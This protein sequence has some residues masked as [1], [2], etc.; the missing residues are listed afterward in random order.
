MPDPDSDLLHTW[1]APASAGNPEREAAIRAG[2]ATLAEATAGE[3]L[4]MVLLA[5][6]V[7]QL[8]PAQRLAAAIAEHDPKFDGDPANQ[9]TQ[10]AAAW[11][12][13]Q[14]LAASGDVA[15]TAALAVASA[16]F[17]GLATQVPELPSLAA[18]TL[19]ERQQLSRRRHPLPKARTQKSVITPDV[20]ALGA[21]TG[22]QLQAT[23]DLLT[24][25]INNIQRSHG[26][27]VDAVNTRVMAADEETDML[28][29]AINERH[30]GDGQRWVELGAAAPL[31]AGW[32]LARLT[33]FATP[34]PWAR[35][36]L[37]RALSANEQNT[38]ADAI[39]ALPA[40]PTA[41]GKP[42]HP[43]LPV[44]CASRGEPSVAPAGHAYPPADLAEEALIEALLERAQP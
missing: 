42:S 38:I 37:A 9:Q 12:V 5:H 32:D 4:D 19:R 2:T 43:L 23:A 24:A 36:L 22:T 16:R 39:A 10:I 11:T 27:M 21:I 3:T 35:R 34:P 41:D 44:L 33:P 6:G 30:E 25:S 28:W 26:L 17:C 15:V 31:L 18:G 7:H 29:W 13:A 8:A 14:T 20:V 1:L 40:M